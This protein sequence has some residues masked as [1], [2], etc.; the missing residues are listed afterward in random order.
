MQTSDWYNL[1]YILSAT[2]ALIVMIRSFISSRALSKMLLMLSFISFISGIGLS[3]AQM[4]TV[5]AREWGDL[6][7]RWHGLYVFQAENLLP[8]VVFAFSKKRC[9]SCAF[10][11][12]TTDAGAP[13]TSGEEPSAAA[14]GNPLSSR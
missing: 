1:L 8:C 7:G 9:E 13:S 11:L 3:Y 14:S 4:F 2:A 5:Q 12:R 6:I 10:G